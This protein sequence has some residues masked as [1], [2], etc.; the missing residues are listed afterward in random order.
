MPPHPSAWDMCSSRPRDWVATASP[1]EGHVGALKPTGTRAPRRTGRGS[2]G[3]P[4]PLHATQPAGPAARVCQQ[5]GNK[6]VNQ[7][8]THRAVTD[9]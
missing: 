7:K 3:L 9:E 2:G 1:A 4:E 6:H 5:L 8:K